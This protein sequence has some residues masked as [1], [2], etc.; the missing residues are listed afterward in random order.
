[1]AIELSIRYP[2]LSNRII[3]G[4]A[5]KHHT[6]AYV[7]SLKQIGLTG[8]GNVNFEHFQKTL[9]DFV[10]ILKKQHLFHGPDYWKKLVLGIS[11]LWSTPKEYS[12]D[13]L[14]S[15]TADILIVIG[16]RD[17]FIPVEEAISLYK[18]I[19]NSA[20]TVLPNTDHALPRTKVDA[21]LTLITDFYCQSNDYNIDQ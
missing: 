21:F 2:Q 4:G 6:E 8:P 9:P 1:M 15:I 20:I 19:P 13:E 3:V 14:A 18:L 11:E 10:E 5:W 16:D 12:V 17:Q 7:H